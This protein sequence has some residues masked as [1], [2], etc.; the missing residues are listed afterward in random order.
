ML[1]VLL[2]IVNACVLM[3]DSTVELDV[4]I[5]NSFK[6]FFDDAI[7]VAFDIDIP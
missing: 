7:G 6:S 1:V 4:V 5:T 3:R 2:L